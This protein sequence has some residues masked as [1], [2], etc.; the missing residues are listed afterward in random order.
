MDN[1]YNE[2]GIAGIADYLYAATCLLVLFCYIL[3][4]CRMLVKDVIVIVKAMSILVKAVNVLGKFMSLLVKALRLF[5]EF[6]GRL[7][8]TVKVLVEAMRIPVLVVGVHENA[9]T[10]YVCACRGQKSATPGCENASGGRVSAFAC[11]RVL[12][13]A[14][15]VVL[16]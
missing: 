14:S 16:L 7:V 13:Q 3:E 9:C 4:D 2:R 10:G 12:V 11:R 1:K 6:M 15:G 5:L 8:Q